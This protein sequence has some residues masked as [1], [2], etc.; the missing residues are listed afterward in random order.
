MTHGLAH[1]ASELDAAA[2]GAKEKTSKRAMLVARDRLRGLL[3]Q[4]LAPEHEN[5]RRRSVLRVTK[6]PRKS[7]SGVRERVYSTVN[8]AILVPITL[9]ICNGSIGRVGQKTST[10]G[11]Q[12]T[13][14][15][16][17]AER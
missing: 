2:K 10:D 12:G 17:S 15:V 4:H 1:V 14:F 8:K 6:V 5:Q 13:N 9:F 3:K 11:N 16:D 7:N